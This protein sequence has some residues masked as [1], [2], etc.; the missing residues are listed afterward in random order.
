M[1][2]ISILSFLILLAAALPARAQSTDIQ[3]TEAAC[4]GGN[5][6]SCFI[7]AYMYETGKLTGK[8]DPERA[9]SYYEDAC[10]LKEYTA[11]F[12]LA[13]NFASSR[14][15]SGKGKSADYRRAEQLYKIA[16]DGGKG[17]ACYNLG[18][19]NSRFANGAAVAVSYYEKAC[20]FGMAEGCLKA[21]LAYY[22]GVPES[23][24]QGGAVPKS[25]KKAREL[26][27]KACKG[28]LQKA[29]L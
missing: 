9:L 4:K 3:K 28:G 21:G 6:H 26:F 2:L 16:C 22:D 13:N 15:K 27:Q 12:N 17:K 29:C 20:R 5:G 19:I 10:R 8:V 14:F 24:G 11:C 23:Q 1:R 7:L 18:Y 25:H